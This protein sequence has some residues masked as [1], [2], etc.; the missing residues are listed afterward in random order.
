MSQFPDHISE[1][2]DWNP[3]EP[4]AII[5]AGKRTAGYGAVMFL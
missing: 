5:H 2:T 4:A 3:S 1:V